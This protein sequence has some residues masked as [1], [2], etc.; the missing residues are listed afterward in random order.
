MVSKYEWKE[1]EYKQEG[2]E[3]IAVEKG[4][5]VNFPLALAWAITI[6]KSQGL[7]FDKVTLHTGHIFAPGQLYVALSRCRS[8]KG[9]VSDAFID[10]RYIISN[11]E[12]R[13]VENA[14]KNNNNIF[15]FKAY[16]NLQLL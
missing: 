15:D 8:L 9:I 5:A 4:S 7:T 10:K 11:P 6:H 12:L 13:A 14:Y 2:K 1:R 3:I 16:K